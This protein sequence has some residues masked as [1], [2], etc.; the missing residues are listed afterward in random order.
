MSEIPF[1]QLFD[2]TALIDDFKWA[3]TTAPANRALPSASRRNTGVEL[4]DIPPFQHPNW[5]RFVGTGFTRYLVKS[6][7]RAFT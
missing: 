5:V 7:I 3:D 6:K 2:A 1:D 4:K